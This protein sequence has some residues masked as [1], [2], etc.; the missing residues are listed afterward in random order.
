MEIIH[1]NDTG[2]PLEVYVI[3][4]TYAS[5]WTT[6]LPFYKFGKHKLYIHVEGI[7]DRR[8]YGLGIQNWI[9]EIKVKGIC[10]HRRLREN[11]YDRAFSTYEKA[12]IQDH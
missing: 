9:S 4:H 1:L 10:S 6:W 8:S 12:L 7:Y 3:D 5:D 11:L 2:L